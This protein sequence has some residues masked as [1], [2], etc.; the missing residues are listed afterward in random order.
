[1]TAGS[2]RGTGL[3]VTDLHISFDGGTREA[4]RGVSFGIAPGEAFGLVGESGSGKSLTC[5]AVL[6]LMPRGAAIS[7]TICFDGRSLTDLSPRAMQDLR[8]DLISMIFQ[9]PTTSLN[10]VITVGESVAQVV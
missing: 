4:V 2:A 7:G 9:D 1:M 8:G 3:Q 6:G 10:P 5:R